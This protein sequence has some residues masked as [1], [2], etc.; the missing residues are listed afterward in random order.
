MHL[1][2]LSMLI[3]EESLLAHLDLLPVSLLVLV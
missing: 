2:V 1:Q 3:L